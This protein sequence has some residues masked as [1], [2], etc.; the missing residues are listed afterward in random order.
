[1]KSIFKIIIVI[2]LLIPVQGQL[3]AQK[4]GHV[5]VNELMAG[6]PEITKADQE[7]AAYQKELENELINK[8]TSLQT[9][10]Q[11][12]QAGEA[13]M[14]ALVRESRIQEIQEMEKQGYDS[15]QIFDVLNQVSMANPGMAPE[16]P[17]G[18]GMSQPDISG[19]Q[20]PD[21]A[22]EQPDFSSKIKTFDN[23]KIQQK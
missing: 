17:P 18:Y 2:G 9:K 4:I 5:N 16:Q 19:Q 15:T 3:M 6:M 14:Q 7:V 20:A 23:R 13:T 12:F 10:Y 22:P 21:Q 8:N 11:E 1:M